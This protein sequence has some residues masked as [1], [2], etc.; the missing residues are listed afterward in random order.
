MTRFTLSRD[1]W[2]ACEFIGDEFEYDRC[3]YSPIKVLDL[4]PQS[5]GSRRLRI[6]FFHANYPPGVQKKV[7][8]LQTIERAERFMLA[9]SLDHKPARLLQIYDVDAAW[10][11]RHFGFARPPESDIGLDRWLDDNAY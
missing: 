5:H 11:R 7:Y 9:R 6:E 3:S 8:M 4:E 1:R 10:V 2:Y